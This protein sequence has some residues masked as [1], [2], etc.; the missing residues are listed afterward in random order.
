[1]A[2]LRAGRPRWRLVVVSAFAVLATAAFPG[3]SAATPDYQGGASAGW[4][5]QEGEVLTANPG[6]WTSTTDITYSYAWFN[7]NGVALGT[8][9]T[10]TITGNDVG[11]QI[12][13]AIRATDGDPPSMI[14]NTPTVG[15]MH[16]RP[17]VNVEEPTVTGPFLEGA[18]LQASAGKWVSGGASAAPIQISYAWY[19]GC[20]TGPKPDC[21]NAGYISG[22]SSLLLSSAD[23]GRPLSLT[24]TGSYPDGAGGQAS[25]SVWL[26]NL[27]PIVSSSVRAGDT[28][29]GTVQWTVTAPGAQ[30]IAIRVNGTQAALQPVDE[31]GVA[32][33][34]LDTTTLANG[35]NR[36][37]VTATWNDGRA[38]TT[39]QIGAVTVSN[40]PTAPPPLVVKPLIGKPTASP[41]RPVAG[42][43]F[44]VT[45]AVTRSDNHQ[46]LTRGKMICNPSLNGKR[47]AHTASFVNGK[48]R[49]ALKIPKTAK[50]KLLKVKLT[51]KTGKQST[52]RTATFLVS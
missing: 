10:Y 38:G 40:P 42:K 45:F 27:G 6:T 7:D 15:P 9:S 24:V 14:V 50:N 4:G 47:I 21:N 22:A 11:H 3:T 17:P 36:L 52:T 31:S 1:M 25:S 49:L 8:G 39:V 32:I 43:R 41:P 33:F 18:T 23:V 37:A 16:Y 29:T 35:S 30:W 28:L 12:Y 51:I 46:P 34:A 19:R 5:Y 48:A 13:A 26:G 44:L 2:A 20:S